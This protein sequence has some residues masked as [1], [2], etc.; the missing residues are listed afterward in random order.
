MASRKGLG[1]L[2]EGV[3]NLEGSPGG[4]MVGLVIA[5]LEIRA[6]LGEGMASGG[7]GGM[8]IG[9]ESDGETGGR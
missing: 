4:S 2:S 5:G 3:E 6:V 1:L 9:E 7:S 8:A